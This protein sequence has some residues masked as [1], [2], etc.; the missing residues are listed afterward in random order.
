MKRLGTV[1]RHGLLWVLGLWLLVQ[2]TSWAALPAADP[3]ASA[4][5]DEASTLQ[6]VEQVTLPDFV[7]RQ[8]TL[9]VL[10][11]YSYLIGSGG[12]AL[13]V[14]PARDIGRYLEDAKALGLKITRVYLTHSHADFIAGHMEL[15]HA[16]GAE[17]LVNEATGAQFPHTGVKDGHVLRFGKVRAVVRATP[18][19]TPDG[20]CLF[21]HHPEETPAPRM[22]LTGDTLFIGSVGRPDLLEG[23]ASSAQLAAMLYRSWTQILSK[24][25]DETRIY[26]AHGAG[27]LCGVHLSDASFSTFGAQKAENPYLRN[28]DEASFVMAVLEGLRDPPQYF[29]HNAAMNRSGPPVIAGE[30]E[31][32]QALS[33]TGL[34]A[35]LN[36]GAWLLDVREA[37]AFASG[38]LPGAMSIP[39]RGRFESWTGIMVP[40][41]APVILT[42]GKGEVLEAR[43]RLHRIGVDRVEGLFP[44]SLD[45]WKQ[46]G[47][48]LETVTLV[49]PSA[50][51]RQMEQGKA[52]LIV[53]VRL[54][55]EWMA[56]RIGRVLNIPLDRLFE[57]AKKRLDPTMP[58]LMVCNSAYRSSL[59]AGIM[60][61]LG[62]RDVRNLRGGSEAWLRE[63]LPTLGA[64]PTEKAPA[65]DAGGSGALPLP[66]GMSPGD[67]AT[68]LM[69]LPGSL[70]LVDLRPAWQFE[71]Y[72]LPGSVNVGVEALLQNPAY[73]TSRRPLVLLCRDGFLSASLAGVL[74]SR[75]G[76]PVRYLRGGVA[77]YYEEIVRPRGTLGDRPPAGLSGEPPLQ[78]PPTG[79][80]DE[81][82]EAVPPPPPQPPK[83]RSAGC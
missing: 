68:R 77:R 78:A 11:H 81:K 39:V 34:R 37:E 32:A 66:E 72:R 28:K 44:D 83:K 29:K 25:P 70:D 33:V 31:D 5:G 26:P 76:R 65:A 45:T 71:A 42:G 30:A 19:H 15:A 56:L 40:W 7:F 79:A 51:H 64:Q 24:V 23:S 14:D 8:Y 69:E 43:A 17:I 50:L 63:G 35:A 61:K 20:T 74:T 67:L 2:G 73:G 58:V 54:P 22:V 12:E 57:E 16:A 53:D 4:H 55:E 49:E 1:T 10:S 75:S 48:P 3:E 6:V 13:I 38:H 36:R 27:S 59:A 62:F 46:A 18:G 21:V 41:G 52:P 60:Q 80:R 82:K 9:G 47:F